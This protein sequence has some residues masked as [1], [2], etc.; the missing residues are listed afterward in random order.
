VTTEP[1]STVWTGWDLRG[2]ASADTAGGPP[3][4]S[5][6]ELDAYELLAVAGRGFRPPRYLTVGEPTGQP[7]EDA[8]VGIREVWAL[9]YRKLVETAP[10]TVTPHAIYLLG[11][12]PPSDLDDDELATFNDFYSTVHLP[13]VA[14]R[15]HALRAVRYELTEV[16]KA[17]YSGAPRFLAS[18]EVDEAGAANRRHTG[19][20]YS[21]G[22]DVW[23]RHTTP[24]RLWYRHL[25]ATPAS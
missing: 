25:D 19:P 11:V 10:R 16:H 2:G 24:W 1:E 14:T 18:Y 15:R 7:G 13:E 8:V 5:T 17:P 23:Q 22:P 21:S 12:N 3:F 9:R 20:P 6:E 4:A